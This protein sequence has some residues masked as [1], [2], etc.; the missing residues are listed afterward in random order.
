MQ[1]LEGV[2]GLGRLG[3]RGLGFRVQVPNN[4]ILSKKCIYI[5]TIR[6]LSILLLD[7]LN[8]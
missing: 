6:T 3:F 2:K 4:H 1:Y 7:P 8:P 5:T